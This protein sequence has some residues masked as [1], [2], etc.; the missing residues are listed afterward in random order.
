[1][2][3]PIGKKVLGP[4]RLFG[5]AV[6]PLAIILSGCGPEGAGSIKIEDP[7]AVR[8]TVEGGGTSTKPLTAKQAKA[9][10]IEAEAA[11]KNPKLQ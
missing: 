1:V 6:V 2:A 5:V 7:Q 3:K 10:E 8:A 4:A 9:K 11:K